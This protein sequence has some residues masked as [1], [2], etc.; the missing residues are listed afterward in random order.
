MDKTKLASLFP[1]PLYSSEI[2]ITNT[3]KEIVRSFQFERIDG[4]SA[5]ISVNKYVL[6][7]PGLEDLR[8]LV[9]DH[10]QDFGH[11]I[12]SPADGVDLV[13]KNSWV[14]EHPPGDYNFAHFHVNSL[15][16]GVLYIDVLPNSGDL[17]FQKSNDN[18]QLGMID[19]GVKEYNPFNSKTFRVTPTEGQILIFPSNLFHRAET[20]QSD[21]TRYCLP[22]NY[23]VKG[24]LGKGGPE[25]LII[26]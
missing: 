14:M 6:N 20:N 5:N 2:T 26:L 7:E 13:L 18:L 24:I 25:E 4:G 9:D 23:F 21:K 8:K 11:K 12:Y 19:I 10:V 15:I 1:T 17:I 16:S 22:F 3:V